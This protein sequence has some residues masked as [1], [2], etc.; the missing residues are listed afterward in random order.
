[1][2]LPN[3]GMN[4]E[5][6]I[7]YYKN[8]KPEYINEYKEYFTNRFTT[9]CVYAFSHDEKKILEVY[10]DRRYFNNFMELLTINN[11]HIEVITKHNIKKFIKCKNNFK[12]NFSQEFFNKHFEIEKTLKN[13][14]HSYKKVNYKFLND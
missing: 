1:M 9:V 7:K 8:V 4:N 14:K 3:R 2:G 10:A 11:Q 13:I 12:L 5:E 6:L